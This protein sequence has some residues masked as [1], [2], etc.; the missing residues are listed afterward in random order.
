MLESVNPFSDKMLKKLI[1]SVCRRLLR[2]AQEGYRGLTKQ[3]LRSKMI[4]I[5][6]RQKEED[7]SRKSKLIEKKLL[8]SRT[9]KKAKIVMFYIAFGGEVNTEDMM[10][11][12]R[13]LGK[14]IA[15]P[16]CSGQ[17]KLIRP[18]LLTEG[19]QLRKG[20]YGVCEPVVTHFIKEQDI[21][22]VLV[23]GLSFD[24]KGNR[25]GR[26]KGC[27][28]RFLAGLSSRTQTIGLAFDFQILPRIPTTSTDVSIQ[29]VLSA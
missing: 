29:K 9:F 15:V 12:A 20:L 3:E 14:V 10:Q 21:D 23:P 24:K 11:A 19:V 16:V 7:R 1:H 13:K 18:S 6:Q 17:D 4:P 26:G 28:D 27:Y 22:L 5:L 8:R 25:L 2:N